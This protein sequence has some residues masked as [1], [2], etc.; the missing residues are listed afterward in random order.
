MRIMGCV[1]ERI[2]SY[3]EEFAEL[4]W[5][6]WLL[7]ALMGVG[8]LYTVISG[9]VQFRYIPFIINEVFLRP[10]KQWKENRTSSALSLTSI[11]ALCT[12]VGSIVGSGNIVG[13]STAIL[14]GGPGA[15]FW[16]W[17]AAI[18]G[19]ATKYGEIV[20]GLRYQERDRSGR[21]V[22]GPMYYIEKGLSCR[23]LGIATAG[24]LFAQNLGGTLIQSNT[25]A[26][27]MLDSF[28]VS[29]WTTGILLALVMS[30]I[31]AGGLKRLAQVAVKIV[32]FMALLYVS[33]GFIVIAVNIL[34]LPD[35]IKSILESAF[36]IRAGIGGAI[37]YSLKE[38]MRYGVARG[39]YSNEAG[40][41]S[42]AVIHSAVVVDHPV[43]Q[44]VYGIVDVFVD[45]MVI[46]STTGFVILLTGVNGTVSNP[47]LMTAAAFGTVAP[48]MSMVV[49]VSLILFASTSLM[50]QWY[51]G[52]ISLLYL[53][54]EKAAWIYRFLFPAAILIGC[55]SSIK[56]VWLIQDCALGLLI[57]PNLTAL[58]ILSPEVRRLSLEFFNDQARRRFEH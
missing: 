36:S 17:I 5:G 12:A 14:Y 15:L 41:G 56:L 54:D 20:L 23:W 13:V 19:M 39:L 1:M 22:G 30:M 47:S 27:V 21:A 44:A 48:W 43:R 50:S 9:F 2:E 45:T 10:Y 58:V 42:A 25:I 16:M 37:G 33:G 24:L 29:I 38:A 7:A 49:S 4:L 8:I 40:E 26:H 35:V 46:C 51:F 55:Q 6:D 31:V 28:S 53:A 11:Q 18:V 3:F 32:P 34:K 57:I 52:H